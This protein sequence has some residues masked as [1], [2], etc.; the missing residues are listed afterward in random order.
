MTIAHPG[1]L[2]EPSANAETPKMILIIKL[3]TSVSR[4]SESK[5]QHLFTSVHGT[6]KNLK[7]TNATE[8]MLTEMSSTFNYERD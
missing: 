6:T 5:K 7:K 1:Q 8:R 3:S 2:I 4:S